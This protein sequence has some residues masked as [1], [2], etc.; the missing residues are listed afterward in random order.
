VTRELKNV[1]VFTL[2]GPGGERHAAELRWIREVVTLGFVTMI[3]GAPPG[4]AGAVNLRG[5][6]VPVLDPPALLHPIATAPARQGD[7]ALI[8]EDRGVV[9]ALRVTQVHEVATCTA[10]AD[11]VVDGRGRTLPLLDPR[12]LVRRA[13]AATQ[14]ARGAREPE[15][16]PAP[17]EPDPLLDGGGAL[18]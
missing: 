5:N 17:A 1:I 7:A 16:E 15:L 2:G 6:L 3:P 13:V 18:A 12:E 14:A 9:A 4:L 11:H 10:S 8:V